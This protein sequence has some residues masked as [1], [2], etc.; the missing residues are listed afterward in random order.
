MD[1]LMEQSLTR[2]RQIARQY[3]LLLRLRGPEGRLQRAEQFLLS[4]M[5][6]E[7]VAALKTCLTA[8]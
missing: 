3:G 8:E 4:V 6:Q 2:V 7:Q 5:T 1:R